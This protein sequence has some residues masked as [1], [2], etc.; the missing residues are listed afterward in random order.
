MEEVRFRRESSR[1]AL[2]AVMV[3]VT[4][5][6][7][8]IVVPMPPPLAQ[9]DLSP[10]LIYSLAVLVNPIASGLAVGLA[11]GIGTLYK[12]MV[13]GWPP[14]FVVGAVLVR[15]LKLCSSVH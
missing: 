8:L 9:Y 10:I 5:V 4:T 1:L 14:I 2:F 7:N 3:A 6:A 13:F 11:Q 15:G 12:T